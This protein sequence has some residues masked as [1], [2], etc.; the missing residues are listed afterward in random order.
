MED[1]TLSVVYFGID[2]SLSGTGMCLL[3]ESLNIIETAVIK[4]K[5]LRGVYR[6]ELIRAEIIDFLS[7]I[8]ADVVRA[9]REEYSFSSKGS[10]VFNLGELGGVVD[11]T[12]F[13]FF[14]EKG[15]SCLYYRIPPGVHK[16]FCILNGAATKGKNKAERQIYLDLIEKHTGEVFDDDNIADAYMLARTLNGYFKACESTD[17]FNGMDRDRKL[18][19]TPP[20]LRKRKKLTPSRIYSMSQDEYSVMVSEVFD[21]TYL[22]F[23]EVV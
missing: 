16:K 1:D 22:I 8:D 12:I 2:Q 7:D 11:M 10:S 4:P 14:R 13:D 18:S 17:F 20:K 19:F 9:T 5:K 6:L 23:Q 21:E 3:D 15:M